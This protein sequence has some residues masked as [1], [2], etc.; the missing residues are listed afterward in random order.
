MS[1]DMFNQPA[2]GGGYFEAKE[3]IG[4]LVLITKVH[5]VY[6][7]PTNVF[8]GKPAPRD[9]AK[10]DLVDLDAPGQDHRERIIVTHPGLVN[11]LVSGA[12][13]IL[14]RVGQIP[15]DKG[16]PAFVLNGHEPQD[17][18]RAQN[19]VQ[20][21]QAAQ[22][23]QPPAQAQTAP[24]AAQVPAQAPVQAQAAPQAQQPAP[25]V[26]QAAQAPQGQQPN[27]LQGMSQDQI[28]ALMAQLGGQ[29]VQQQPQQAGPAY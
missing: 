12:T 22:Y 15:T 7:N 24:Q 4:H 5:E 2:Q 26:P 14:G 19:W 21:W 29:Q 8:G 16:N 11:R 10:V 23:S 25:V 6:H 28:A 27:P 20:M 18:P 3:A 13:N 9:E 1:D 17:V